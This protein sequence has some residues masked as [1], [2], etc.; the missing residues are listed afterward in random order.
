MRKSVIR[1]IMEQKL[2]CSIVVLVCLLHGACALS[3]WC[4]Q[5]R[6][7]L[8][9]HYA[10]KGIYTCSEIAA[11]LAVAHGFYLRYNLV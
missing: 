11:L 3:L 6:N 5:E 9:Y 1:Q 2:L 4:R 8:I 7:R 10:I